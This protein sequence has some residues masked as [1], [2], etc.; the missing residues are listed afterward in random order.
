MQTY[1]K[2]I[3]LDIVQDTPPYNTSGRLCVQGRVREELK[4]FGLNSRVLKE[5]GPAGIPLVRISGS[6]IGIINYLTRYYADERDIDFY[7]NEMKDYD[8]R[9]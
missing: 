3:D 8:E 9:T 2:Y 4:E 7:I 5:F 6:R 1:K